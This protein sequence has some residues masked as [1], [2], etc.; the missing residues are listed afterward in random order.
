MIV[1]TVVELLPTFPT[2]MLRNDVQ[3]QSADG[4][5]SWGFMPQAE[6]PGATRVGYRAPVVYWTRVKRTSEG[7]FFDGGQ[8]TWGTREQDEVRIMKLYLPLDFT[9]LPLI[10][11]GVKKR[12]DL[13]NALLRYIEAN[14]PEAPSQAMFR[15]ANYDL[16]KLA[17][18]YPTERWSWEFAMHSDP[19]RKG[20]FFGTNI[21][22]SSLFGF[23]Q[24][25]S[26]PNE[27]GLMLDAQGATL[28]VR[29]LRLGRVQFTQFTDGHLIAGNHPDMGDPWPRIVQIL[30]TLQAHRG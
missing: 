7:Y 4:S 6:T 14:T 3:S 15:L 20:K 1:L 16:S 18:S 27:V 30:Q 23:V 28:K 29:I 9:Q 25:G 24:S 22:T 10:A 21:E 17:A 13:E 8:P 2:Q 5:E 26:S 11:L 12:K 19:I